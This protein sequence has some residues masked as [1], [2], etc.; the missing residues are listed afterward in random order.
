MPVCVEHRAVG[1]GLALPRFVEHR[2]GRRVGARLGADVDE[3][4]LGAGARVDHD[5]FVPAHDTRQ[6]VDP[7][8]PDL[9]V[10]VEVD[11]Q[12]DPELAEVAGRDDAAC[13]LACVGQDFEVSQRVVG[14]FRGFVLRVD[15]LDR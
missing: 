2:G 10:L 3:A 12:P 1:V 5:Q 11:L 7:V 6:L 8:G 13:L 9:V 4:Y 14:A 15:A